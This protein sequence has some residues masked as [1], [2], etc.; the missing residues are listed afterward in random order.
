MFA[1]VD[2]NTLRMY[3]EYQVTLFMGDDGSGEANSK[4]TNNIR[5]DVK[6]LPD[7]AGYDST[8]KIPFFKDMWGAGS[9]FIDDDPD[10]A[11]Q[12]KGFDLDF[13]TL[14]WTLVG[15]EVWAEV[16]TTNYGT[17]ENG[18]TGDPIG[19]APFTLSSTGVL[20]PTSVLSAEG[21][22]TQMRVYVTITDGKSDPIGKT[23]YFKVEDTIDDGTLVVRGKLLN[24]ARYHL[25]NC[26]ADLDND[27][28]QDGGEPNAINWYG[29]FNLAITKSST[30]APILAKGGVN[31]DTEPNKAVLRC[32]NNKEV[33][34]R[35]GRIF[36]YTYIIRISFNAKS[37]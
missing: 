6:N 20:K 24:G 22:L 29:N 16:S 37:R 4:T 30:D 18:E 9:K 28:I 3:N 27:G 33:V 1:N 36:T 17:M 34:N 21:N 35:M 32:S 19:N 26:M 14:T 7:Y 11:I 13:D 2:P 5:I 10:Q 31:T 15:M 12:I 8:N 23:F 25:N